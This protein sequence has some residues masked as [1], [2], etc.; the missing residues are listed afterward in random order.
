MIIYNGNV[1]LIMRIYEK[2]RILQFTEKVLLKIYYFKVL[3]LNK[4]YGIISL[5]RG[6]DMA[7]KNRIAYALPIIQII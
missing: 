2:H 1:S 6:N 5:L 4:R 3:I 7:T